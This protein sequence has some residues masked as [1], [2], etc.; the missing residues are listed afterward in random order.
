VYG[1]DTY[2]TQGG[3][4]KTQQKYILT[5]KANSDSVCTVKVLHIGKSLVKVQTVEGKGADTEP[6]YVSPNDWVWQEV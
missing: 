5:G 3:E 1:H 6:Y 2:N 4:M